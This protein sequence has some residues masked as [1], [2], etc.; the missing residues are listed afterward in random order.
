MR[1]I[2]PANRRAFIARSAAVIGAAALGDGL[3][4][5]APTD[6]FNLVIKGGQV[7]DPSQG[8]NGRVDIGIR[9]GRIAA[10][11]PDIP[12]TRATRVIDARGKLVTPGLIDLH[13]HVFPFGTAIG[14]PAD[15]LVPRTCVTT[16]VS[17]GDAGAN[18]FAAF[19][20]YVA[21]QA[22]C[23]IYAFVHVANSGLG[24]YPAPEMLNI[25]NADVDA[26]A[27][28]IAENHA[29]VLGVKVRQSLNVVGSNGLEPLKRAIAAVER[30]GTRGRVM[31]HA[32]L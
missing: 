27:R 14:V 22:R 20:R 8:L 29:M 7:L 5:Q 1:S 19:K 28:T 12:D 17:A 9:S 4:A 13:A 10:I 2:R 24:G 11:E 31:C 15:E 32:R 18:N 26:A 3:F 23:R 25:D 6:K 16:F 30:A 21:S